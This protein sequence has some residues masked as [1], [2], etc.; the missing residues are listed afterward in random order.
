[1]DPTQIAPLESATF[2]AAIAGRPSA[3]AVA[4]HNYRLDIFAMKRLFIGLAAIAASTAYA[5]QP[6]A[7]DA[8]A[9]EPYVSM[10][11]GCHSIPGYQASFPRVYR[12][13]KIAGQSA[14]YIESAL[15]AYAKGQRSHPTMD[16]IAGTLTD[17]Q[18]A[19]IAAYYAERGAS[20]K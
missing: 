19:D 7:G 16:A 18:I 14:G 10:C 4:F 11:R 3:R 9:A 17:K 13:P 5:Q 1:L 12:V 20:T 15:H 8:K 6:A 2:T